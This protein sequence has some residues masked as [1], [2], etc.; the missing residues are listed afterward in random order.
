MGDR[1]ATIIPP[2]LADGP[3]LPTVLRRFW[4]GHRSVARA[5]LIIAAA[6]AW[7]F[8]PTLTQL[9]GTWMRDPQYSHG[10]LVPIFAAALLWFR[11]DR[12]PAVSPA[13]AS[14]LAL[15]AVGIAVRLYGALEHSPWPEQISLLPFLLGLV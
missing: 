7:A 6:T 4:S 15:L 13:P 9:Y 3:S 14:G 10:L 12:F 5:T 11:R 1:R 8:W 2:E